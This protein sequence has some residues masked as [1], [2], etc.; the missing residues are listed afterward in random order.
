MTLHFGSDALHL[1]HAA[2]AHTDNDILV[3]IPDANL[4]HTG[5]I[6]FNA[7]YHVSDFSTGGWVGW[8]VAAEDR[9]FALCDAQTASSQAMGP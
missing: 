6:L 1:E 5:D 8:M 2:P 4:L 7:V 9:A 3:H